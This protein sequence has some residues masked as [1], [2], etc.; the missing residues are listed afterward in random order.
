MVIISLNNFREPGSI[1]MKGNYKF[2]LSFATLAACTSAFAQSTPPTYEADPSVYKII[3]EDQNF[4][5]ITGTWAPG[6]TDKPHSHPVASVVYTLTDCTLQVTSA[7]GK[8]VTI[9]PKAGGVTAVPITASHTGRNIGPAECRAVF[10][11]RK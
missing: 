9:T 8:T 2:V 5:V 3:F 7:D 1:L 10:I 4:R 11:E 6:V